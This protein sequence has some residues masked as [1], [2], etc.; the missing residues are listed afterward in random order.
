M[1]YIASLFFIYLL[2]SLSATSQNYYC[3]CKD[4]NENGILFEEN[5][6]AKVYISPYLNKKELYYN[7]WG[8]GEIELVNGSIIKNKILRYNGFL[9]ELV[10]LRD[11]DK[12][13]GLIEK[14]FVK[15]FKIYNRD[16]SSKDIFKKLKIKHWYSFDTSVVYMQV[17][18]EGTISLYAF[19][20]IILMSNLQEFVSKY[21]YYLYKDG[22]YFMFKPN[23]INL[24]QLMGTEKEKMKI[25]LRTNHLKVRH[26]NQLIKAI[27]LYNKNNIN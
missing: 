16:L 20:K 27:E 9:D 10:W 23:R 24:L 4:S 21:E 25:I 15:S 6:S 2:T 11:A 3:A 5:V 18:T 19:R 22:N 1:K 14:Q 7:S 13:T 17:L 8:I 12:K 26:E